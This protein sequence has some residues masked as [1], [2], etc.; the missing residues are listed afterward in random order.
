MTAESAHAAGYHSDPASVAA[1]RPGTPGPGWCA[2]SSRHARR[3]QH[4]R[5]TDQGLI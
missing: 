5:G 4:E 2:A 1:E 3:R